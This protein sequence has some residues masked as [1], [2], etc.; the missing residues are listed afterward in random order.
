MSSVGLA[1]GTVSTASGYG[2]SCGNIVSLRRE[3]RVAKI[4]KPYT[5]AF[6]R[7]DR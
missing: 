6:V 1:T 4:P 5:I 3:L 7:L 2:G